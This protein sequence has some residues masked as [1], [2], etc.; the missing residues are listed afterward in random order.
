MFQFQQGTYPCNTLDQ[1]STGGF[2]NFYCIGIPGGGSSQYAQWILQ[3]MGA[4]PIIDQF[5]TP[6][7]TNG[8]ILNL[9]STAVSS[10]AANSKIML[11]WARPDTVNGVGASVFIR[12]IDGRVPTNQRG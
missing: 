7:Q 4:P 1:E 5:S 3:G 12:N 11:V 10:V 8:V 2:S 9:T 6:V